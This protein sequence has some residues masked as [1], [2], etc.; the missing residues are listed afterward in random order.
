MEA[1]RWIQVTGGDTTTGPRAVLGSQ[2]PPTRSDAQA[3]PTPVPRSDALRAEDGSRSVP[4][5]RS[6]VLVEVSTP[7]TPLSPLSS[8]SPSQAVQSKLVGWRHL[9]HYER[10][11]SR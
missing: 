4:F 2:Q 6:C 9:R 11:R 3:N 8:I 7:P 5:G 1:A 10:V